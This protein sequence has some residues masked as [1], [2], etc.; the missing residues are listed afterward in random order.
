MLIKT[1][2]MLLCFIKYVEL[3]YIIHREVDEALMKIL[4]GIGVRVPIAI[5]IAVISVLRIRRVFLNRRY[6]VLAASIQFIYRTFLENKL[7]PFLRVCLRSS[8][9]R[10]PLFI[11]PL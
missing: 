2:Y 10:T 9:S 8:P 5:I 3:E 7:I 6:D 11:I 4:H 1:N